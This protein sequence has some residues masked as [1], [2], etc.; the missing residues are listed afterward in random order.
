MVQI[1]SGIDLITLMS[2]IILLFIL[3]TDRAGYRKQAGR[4]QV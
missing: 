3:L 4:H 1:G 2:D